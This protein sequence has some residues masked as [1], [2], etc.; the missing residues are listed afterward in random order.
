MAESQPRL[1]SETLSGVPRGPRGSPAGPRTLR[2]SLCGST[3]S[4]VR[5]ELTSQQLT[6]G[7]V[8][9]E[10]PAWGRIP[11]SSRLLR[12]TSH[13][14]IGS[15]GSPRREVPEGSSIW[16]CLCPAASLSGRAGAPGGPQGRGACTPP[17]RQDGAAPGEGRARLWECAGP[18]VRPHGGGAGWAAV[19]AALREC[20]DVPAPGQPGS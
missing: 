4:T 12:G 17:R 10:A 20:Q 8:S 3:V 16:G 19:E 13:P 9:R 14:L 2:P 6:G 1:P 11:P 5:A 7:S 18:G 15:W